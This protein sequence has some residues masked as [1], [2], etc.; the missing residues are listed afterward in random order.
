M[1][2]TTAATAAACTRVKARASAVSVCEV[3]FIYPHT[4][5]HSHAVARGGFLPVF[6]S[7]CGSVCGREC[8][9]ESVVVVVVGS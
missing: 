1:R 5:S 9:G 6:A 8:E 2:N 7:V 3:H 4:L